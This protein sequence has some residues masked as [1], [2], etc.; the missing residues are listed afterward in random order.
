MYWFV[1]GLSHLCAGHLHQHLMAVNCSSPSLLSN[2]VCHR[3]SSN[4]SYWASQLW[5]VGLE[6]STSRKKAWV[7]AKCKI[8]WLEIWNFP[9]LW[10]N[11][12]VQSL[13]N[14]SASLGLRSFI[15]ETKGRLDGVKLLPNIRIALSRFLLRVAIYCALE[16]LSKTEFHWNSDAPK[17]SSLGASLSWD[18][19]ATKKGSSGHDQLCRRC[20]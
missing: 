19:N 2:P 12:A 11:K 14:H 9:R 18:K 1:A 8:K 4:V 16:H 6:K 17:V 3:Y 7:V 20:T 10:W 5:H 13:P 15:C